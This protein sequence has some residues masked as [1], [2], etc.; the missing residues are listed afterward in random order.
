MAVQ[1]QQQK[2]YYTPEEYLALERSADHKSE[3]FQ[4][5]I[6]D[7]AG[8]NP[9]HSVIT[10]NIAREVSLQL[11]GKPCQAFSNDMKVRASPSGL[12][13]Y[14]DLSVVCG[15]PRYHDEKRDVLINPTVLIE[16]L[17][18]STE[19]FDRGKKFAQYQCNETLSDYILIAQDEPRIEHFTRQQDDQW[20]L[21]VTKGLEA[22]LTIASIGC[23][24]AL[25]EV[26][27]RVEFK[28]QP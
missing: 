18:D 10:V 12:F 25:S 15:P 19:A 23:T 4:G 7:M 17:S 28:A 2:H 21:V 16:V 20:L 14:P 22:S 9:Q 13:A 26:Y 3:Y 1:I 5:E 24:L 11:K 6:Y 27:D 8:S